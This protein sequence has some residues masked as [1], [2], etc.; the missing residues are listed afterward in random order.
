M[1]TVLNLRNFNLKYKT[2][3]SL[4][5]DGKRSP[6]LLC[7]LWLCKSIYDFITGTTSLTNDASLVFGQRFFRLVKG[8]K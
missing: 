8:Q 2:H 3:E 6:K 1:G 5:I 7:V 4:D